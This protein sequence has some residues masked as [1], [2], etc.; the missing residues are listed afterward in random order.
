MAD[1]YSILGVDRTASAREIRRAYRKLALEKHPD[2][3]TDKVAAE[4]ELKKLN[5]AYHVL[6]DPERRRT[7][8]ELGNGDPYSNRRPDERPSRPR[9]ERRKERGGNLNVRTTITSE[10]ART[11]FIRQII[12]NAPTRC[13]RCEGTGADPTRRAA[14]RPKLCESCMGGGC[15]RCFHKGFII[16]PCSSCQGSGAIETARRV[17]ITVPAG[18]TNGAKVLVRGE[19]MPSVFPGAPSGDLLVEVRVTQSPPSPTHDR[20]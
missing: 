11:G 15:R 14:M 19:G 1:L 2:R 20:T 6:G 12:V 10:E 8:D 4:A 17:T 7:Y 9:K 16:P 18:V 5:A 13:D 3:N